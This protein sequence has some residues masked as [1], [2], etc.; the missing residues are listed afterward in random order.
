MKRLKL[1]ILSSA[2]LALVVSAPVASSF[3]SAK[4]EKNP[5][6]ERPEPKESGRAIREGK[7][8]VS[9]R[10]RA[11]LPSSNVA[12]FQEEF[13]RIDIQT[14][15]KGSVIEVDALG[16]TER[17]GQL[18]VRVTSQSENSVVDR[19]IEQEFLIDL[20]VIY[21]SDALINRII[22]AT[23]SKSTSKNPIDGVEVK[24]IGAGAD[25]EVTKDYTYQYGAT[26]I[27]VPKGFRYDR[28][29][30][31]RAFWVIIDKDSLSN[32]AP[33]FHDFL[34]RNGGKLPNNLVTPYRSFSRE[35][36]DKLFLELMTNCGVDF[37]RRQAAY[38]A[39]R[40][41]SGWAW[42]G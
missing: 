24:Q 33:L 42:R 4:R 39:V 26:K 6:T 38:E 14:R 32:V 2:V 13:R 12:A 36:T 18:K 35:E 3:Q 31:P 7:T 30:I 20:S 11:P 1:I 8:S 17:K 34:Y 37:L 22:I 10:A 15:A 19:S 25:Y 21:V 41:F 23:F 40:N 29:S 27:T 16:D 9:T 5:S 28:A